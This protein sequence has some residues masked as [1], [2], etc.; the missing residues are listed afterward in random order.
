MIV[1]SGRAF[2]LTP[3]AANSRGEEEYAA[4]PLYCQLTNEYVGSEKTLDFKSS[5]LQFGTSSVSFSFSFSHRGL[6]WEVPFWKNLYSIDFPREQKYLSFNGRLKCPFP[7]NCSG[8]CG[9]SHFYMK[10]ASISS[11]FLLTGILTEIRKEI[12]HV[13]RPLRKKKVY[14]FCKLS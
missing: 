12:N 5:F 1:Q 11:D 3:T 7:S 14:G 8:F 10:F 4:K 2:T 6:V 13:P 9:R